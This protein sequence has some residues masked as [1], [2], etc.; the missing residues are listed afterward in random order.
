MEQRLQS[1]GIQPSPQWLEDCRRYLEEQGQSC[2]EDEILHQILNNDLRDVIR[3]FDAVDLYPSLEN[4]PP[5]V[6]LRKA[7][8]S[9]NKDDQNQGFKAIIPASF[10][11]MAQ[12][13]E[14]LDVSLNAEE[15]LSLGPASSTSPAPIGNQKKRCLKML[16]SDGYFNDGDCRRS[17]MGDEGKQ[18]HV[19]AMETEPIPSLSVQ[20]KPGIKIILSGPI[21]VRF[22]VLML[23]QG[24]TTVLGGCMPSLVPVQKKAIDLAAKLAGV[25]IDPT[26]RALVWNPDTGMEEDDDEG[27]GESGDIHVR[28][29]IVAQQQRRPEPDFP[30]TSLQEADLARNVEIEAS[31]A[32]RNGVY[33]AQ[34]HSISVSGTNNFPADS[35]TSQQNH[36]L[37][38]LQNR[39]QKDQHEQQ[40]PKTQ[41]L[42]ARA[43]A[44]TPSPHLDT[45]P[46]THPYKRQDGPCSS[47]STMT[48]NTP[49]SNQRTSIRNPY[50]KN[51]TS[52]MTKK[53]SPNLTSTQ[54]NQIHSEKR[55]SREGPETVDLTSPESINKTSAQNQR[56]GNVCQQQPQHRKLSKVLAQ[57][58]TSVPSSLN[59]SLSPTA[60]C[61]PLSFSELAGLLKSIIKD[62]ERYSQYERRTFIV[63]CKYPNK[64]K[65]KDF[66]GFNIE[67]IKGYKKKTSRQKSEKVR[68]YRIQRMLQCR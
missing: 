9:S 33:N 67:K 47:Q 4:S 19:V 7:I 27:E 63:P 25:G 34:S 44:A 36:N 37:H 28:E 20:S 40:Q 13:E 12:I 11:C 41:H 14:L 2:S 32:R 18:L 45:G 49:L 35:S 55:T 21:N 17:S 23:D 16:L 5:S 66:M 30:N 65:S 38:P 57:K 8:E 59:Q 48:S 43:D 24:N 46:M 64:K 52:A 60:L 53:A 22:G 1:I 58:S 6:I 26:F 15:R 68:D 3:R 39:S 31:F 29:S 10:K 62:P 54:S 51:N 61:E 56:Q 42:P 50:A